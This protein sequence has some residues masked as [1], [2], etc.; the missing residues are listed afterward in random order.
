MDKIKCQKTKDQRPK[1][2][3]QRPKEQKSMQQRAKEQNSKIVNYV[4]DG[5]VA[6]GAIHLQTHALEF[7]VY[8]YC[9]LFLFCGG[10]GMLRLGLCL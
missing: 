2:K 3:D 8:Q 6:S 1:T 10:Y 7:S 9:C 4:R 5:R